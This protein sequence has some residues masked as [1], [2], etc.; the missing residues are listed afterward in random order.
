M[1]KITEGVESMW[2]YHISHDSNQYMSL[3]GKQV[4]H[5]SIPLSNWGIKSDHI[6]ES[7][8]TE[9]EKE[10]NKRIIK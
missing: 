8:C 6:P 7:Y 10:Y 3:C 4:M 2:N 5:T 9:C 1:Y